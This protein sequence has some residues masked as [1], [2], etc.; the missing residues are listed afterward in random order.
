MLGQM[1]AQTILFFML[2]GGAAVV[3][4]LLCLYMLLRQGN[5]IAAD[6]TPPMRLRRWAAAFFG[7]AALGHMW[8]YLFYIV[9]KDVGS[10]GYVAAVVLDCVTMLITISGTLLSM[11]QDR[12]RPVWPVAVAS[13]PIVVLGGLQIAWPAVGFLNMALVYT[14]VLYVSFTIYMVVAVRQ[15]GRW[16]CDNY[17]DLEHKEVWLS[18]TLLMLVLLMVICYGFT[19]D[20]LSVFLLRIADFVLFG[21]LLWRVE[22]LPQLDAVANHLEEE[23]LPAPE[24]APATSSDIA[25]KEPDIMEEQRNPPFPANI[26][27][28]LDEQCVNTGLYLQHDLTL[29]QLSAVVGINRSYLSQYFSSQGMNYNVY[30]NSLRINHFVRLYQEAAAAERTCTVQQ[31]ASDSG[32]RSYS[33]FS[34]AFKQRMGQSVTAWI[35]EQGV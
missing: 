2:Y 16:L 31:L 21:L 30:I 26:A 14:L 13:I 23:S 8:W 6:I 20:S 19:T 5:A 35:R 9:S 3:A 17:A 15:Y 11:L 29:A 10:W 34:L 4:A 32:Y 1:T 22:T 12:R 24:P 7:I 25:E 18:H 27:Q 28:L 33:T